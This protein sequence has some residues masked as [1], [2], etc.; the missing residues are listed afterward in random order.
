MPS[1]MAAARPVFKLCL[2]LMNLNVSSHVSLRVTE[3]S[4]QLLV[5]ELYRQ[6]PDKGSFLDNFPQMTESMDKDT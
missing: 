4:N 5:T 6:W 2:I 3:L 1:N